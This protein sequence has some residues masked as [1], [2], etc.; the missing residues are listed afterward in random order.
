MR[1]FVPFARN[2]H[3]DKIYFIVKGGVCE[4]GGINT[5]VVVESRINVQVKTGG[6]Y[7]VGGLD[8]TVGEQPLSVRPRPAPINFET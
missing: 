5:G 2:S 7:S 6:L 3:F 1:V 4:A 8:H